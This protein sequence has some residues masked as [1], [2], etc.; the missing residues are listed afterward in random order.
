MRKK[1]RGKMMCSRLQVNII[2]YMRLLF[3]KSTH[4][5]ITILIICF[6]Q[7]YHHILE[8]LDTTTRHFHTCI[9]II[10]LENHMNL[11]SYSQSKRELEFAALCVVIQMNTVK[12]LPFFIRELA[13]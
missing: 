6:Y 7:S 4:H 12:K 8:S 9:G 10:D 1:Q 5:I 3:Q 13:V 2:Y 11:L